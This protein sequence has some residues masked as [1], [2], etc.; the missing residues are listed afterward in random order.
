MSCA[1][2]VQLASHKMFLREEKL[3]ISH[4][5]P[6]CFHLC[7]GFCEKTTRKEFHMQA[8]NKPVAKKG[9][10]IILV[11]SVKRMRDK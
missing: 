3:L 6:A 1:W 4:A 2:L 10:K 7:F 5:L 8:C 11:G 9:A